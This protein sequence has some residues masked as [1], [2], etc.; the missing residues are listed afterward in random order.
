MKVL[1]HGFFA[2]LCEKHDVDDAVF[3]VDGATPLKGACRRHGLGFRYEKHGIRDSIERV[4]FEVK[5][6]TTSFSDY[7]SNADAETDD[8]WLRSFAFEWNQLM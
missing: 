6:R 5:R 3:P 4:F 1:A 8:Q 7:F 2:E